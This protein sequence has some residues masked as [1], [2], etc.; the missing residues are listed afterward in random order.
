LESGYNVV[1]TLP[2]GY[3]PDYTPFLFSRP[4]HLKLQARDWIHFYLL[5]SL[6]SKVMAEVSFHIENNRAVSPAKAPFGSFAFSERLAPQ[7][8]YSFIG[9]C[10]E[11][12]KQQGIVGLSITEPPLFYRKSE[13][14]LQTILLNQGFRIRKAEVSSGIRVDAVKFED[15]IE[16]WE[17]RKLKQAK[18]KGITC[19]SLPISELAMLYDFILQCRQQ[20]GNS[21]SMTF[22]ELSETV[23]KFKDSFSL[24][25][26]FH[27][28]ELAA[29][30]ITIHVRP[31]ILYNFYSAHLRKFDAISP[32]VLL[33]NHM[34][35]FCYGHDFEL[36][37]LGTSAI[38][39]Q[40]NFSLLD[41]KLR[42]GAV[43]SMKLSFEKDLS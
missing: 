15:K 36:L 28:K 25:A 18:A 13:E 6:K 12:L 9:D 39:G 33:M 43:P 31:D 20:R 41:F 21:L 7:L 17:R 34:Y 42:L 32:M 8:L 23:S 35:R 2:P 22:D 40:P 10:L 24:F 29:A 14:L 37:D 27:E 5:R 11:N 1:H 19:K 3:K 38:N 30:S 26:A 4:E 16:T